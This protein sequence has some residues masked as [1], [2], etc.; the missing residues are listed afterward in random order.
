MQAIQLQK[1]IDSGNCSVR[2]CFADFAKGFDIIDHSKLLDE[3]KSF[4]IDQTLFF[5]IRSFLTNR[6]QVVRVASSQS[7]WK[8]VNG[9]VPRGTKFG[10]TLFTVL[11]NK[12][13]INWHMRTKYI[14]DTTAFE[15]IPRNSFSMLDVV[16]REIQDYCIEHKMTL[17]PK[18]VKKCT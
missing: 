17:N 4:N 6:T 1:A 7:L 16:V 3:L 9:G 8:Q 12:L 10:L 14:D 5:W 2:I 13:L 18:N 11:V 15:I